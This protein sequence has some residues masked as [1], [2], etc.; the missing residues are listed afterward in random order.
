MEASEG[1]QVVTG[2]PFAN[3]ADEDCFVEDVLREETDIGDRDAL[4][5]VLY[6]CAR[7]LPKQMDSTISA[8]L[9]VCK[10]IA[11][12]CERLLEMG[13]EGCV[14]S[15]GSACRECIRVTEDIRVHHHVRLSADTLSSTKGLTED[16]CMFVAICLCREILSR[17]E[18]PEVRVCHLAGVPFQGLAVCALEPWQVDVCIS[19]LFQHQSTIRLDSIELRTY[20]KELES[21]CSMLLCA[22][23]TSAALMADYAIRRSQWG[24]AFARIKAACIDR[25]THTPYANVQEESRPVLSESDAESDEEAVRVRSET[26]AVDCASALQEWFVANIPAWDGPRFREAVARAYKRRVMRP[27]ETGR[28][29]AFAG[30]SF[31]RRSRGALDTSEE[32]LHSLPFEDILMID[33][34]HLV[35][36]VRTLA[37]VLR[38]KL[39][40]N[41]L[42]ADSGIQFMQGFVFLDSNRDKNKQLQSMGTRCVIVEISGR[43]CVRTSTSSSKLYTSLHEALARWY[44][45]QMVRDPLHLN[46]GDGQQSRLC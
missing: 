5:M 32:A 18:K 46:R 38:L 30:N 20:V 33:S 27:D 39:M 42:E 16:A 2:I 13:E 28:N 36:N 21:R 23:V 8:R 34:K 4:A 19:A 29:L 35:G 14:T 11:E 26:V 3:A 10:R 24:C 15:V 7:S 22:H 31:L 12:T 40:T 17:I 43:W 44:S 45:T 41:A 37:D 25:V 1:E 6:D 9:R